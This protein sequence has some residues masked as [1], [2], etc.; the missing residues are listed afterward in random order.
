MLKQF[1][2]DVVI[3]AKALS[4]LSKKRQGPAGQQKGVARLANVH[5]VS[6]GKCAEPLP[7]AARR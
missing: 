7:V 5:V 6:G 1:L 2:A 4:N 3:D